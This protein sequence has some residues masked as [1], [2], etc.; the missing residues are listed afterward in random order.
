MGPGKIIVASRE[1]QLTPISRGQIPADE[2]GFVSSL[3]RYDLVKRKSTELARAVHD[4]EVTGDGKQVLLHTG[5]R[6]R[7]VPVDGGP[8]TG[9]RVTA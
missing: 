6:L 2:G 8:H 9:R 4:F 5:R 7:L 3:V 1:K